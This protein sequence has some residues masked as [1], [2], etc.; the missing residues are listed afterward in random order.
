MSRYFLDNA[1]YFVTVPTI[2]H[3]KFF[4][5]PKKKQ[6]ILSKLTQA[7]KQFNLSDMDFSII[8]H[9]YHFVVYFNE[10]KIIPKMLQLINGGSAYTLNKVSKNDSPVWDEY[11]IY[12]VQSEL[13]LARVQGY[14]TGNPLKH[15]EVKTLNELRT[16]PFSSYSS[17]E[18]RVGEITARE[19]VQSA[20]AVDERDL[21][22]DL[23][24]ANLNSS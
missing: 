17:L 6:I 19:Y 13:A 22:H 18:K 1:Y 7:A 23:G 2:R 8:S 12:V 16:Y 15:Q 11:F 21:L 10:G 14:V 9:H 5:S 20:I 3:I 24:K 4:D